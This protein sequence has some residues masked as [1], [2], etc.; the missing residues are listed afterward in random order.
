MKCCVPSRPPRARAKSETG[1][2][3]STT[4]QRQFESEMMIVEK[5][6]FDPARALEE[7]TASVDAEVLAAWQEQIAHTVPGGAA[8]L[9]VGGYGRRQLFPYSDVDLLLL[10]ANEKAVAAAKEPISHFLQRLWD[11]GMRISH[12]VRTPA[13]CVELHDQNIELNVSLLD[14]R[15]LTG[16]AAVYGALLERLPRFIHSQRDGLIRHLSQ[17][18]RERHGRY[19]NT[20][21]HL[22]PNVKE[23][24]GG[25]RDLQLLSW[26]NQIASTT[27]GFLA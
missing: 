19:N 8:L 24:P 4:W 10:F 7:R 25:L 18:T 5:Q 11:A 22:E 15:F 13:E 17:M 16:D 23:A 20:F 14:Q 12:S 2:F 9:A 6:L 21:H 27:P 1:R 26:L 3:S